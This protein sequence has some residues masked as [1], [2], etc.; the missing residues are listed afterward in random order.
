MCFDC[1][2]HKL[3]NCL[4]I[5]SALHLKIFIHLF[6]TPLI[7]F[8][9][10]V[11]WCSATRFGEK[12]TAINICAKL[13]GTWIFLL[14]LPHSIGTFLNHYKHRWADFVIEEKL[15]LSVANALI[16]DLRRY[17][18]VFSFRPN[19]IPTAR[20]IRSF[21]VQMETPTIIAMEVNM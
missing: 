11:I 16:T 4:I 6:I 8:R 7:K 10:H 9:W 1:G 12:F 19:S 20:L 13:C 17:F 5:A 15:F 21:T 14:S 18:L 2:K 3:F